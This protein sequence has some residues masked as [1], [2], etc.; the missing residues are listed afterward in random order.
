MNRQCWSDGTSL[1]V[2]PVL[3]YLLKYVI[4]SANGPAG[5]DDSETPDQQA[6]LIVRYIT[7]GMADYEALH[8]QVI[9]RHCSS[10]LMLG[11]SLYINILHADGIEA[12]NYY[13]CQVKSTNV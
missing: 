10:P 13:L 3:F 11:T 2:A 7:S 5:L 12:C 9:A 1:R 6:R 4:C 8:L